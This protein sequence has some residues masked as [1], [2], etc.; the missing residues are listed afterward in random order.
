MS[1]F[2]NTDKRAL[3]A[4]ATVTRRARH[5]RLL[6]RRDGSVDDGLE[7]GER[8]VAQ[9]A[10]HMDGAVRVVIGRE[11]ANVLLVVLLIIDGWLLSRSE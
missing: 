6:Y 8:F 10:R 11:P 2:S 1:Q 5:K 7:P 3:N 4:D 9:K